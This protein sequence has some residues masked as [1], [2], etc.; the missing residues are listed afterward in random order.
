MKIYIYTHTQNIWCVA[1]TEL[2]GTF[3]AVDAYIYYL[4]NGSILPV[5]GRIY[6]FS[7]S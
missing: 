5:S 2:K 4:P 6:I 3:T 7:S 1:K